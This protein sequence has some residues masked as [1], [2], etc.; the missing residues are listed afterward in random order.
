MNVLITGGAGFIGS[1]LA[2]RLLERGDRVQVIDDLSTGSKQNI[3]HLQ[4]L[5]SFHFSADT[6]TNY[7][8]MA[9]LVDEADVVYHLA[10]AVGV[11]LI[12]ESPTRTMETNI[13]GTEIVLE[14]AARARKRVL[15]TST[16]EVYGKRNHVPFREDDDLVLGPPDKGRWSYACSKAIDEFLA[17]AYWKE[18]GL[19]T[20]VARLFNVVGP[21]QTGR[22]GMVLPNLVKQALSGSD[23][24]VYGDGRQSRCFTYVDDAVGALIALADSP[25]ANGEVYNVGS[26]EEISILDLAERIRK[27]TASES[28]I[29]LVPYEKAYKEGFEDMMRRVPDL[30]KISRAIGYRPSMDLGQILLSTVHYHVEQSGLAQKNGH[31]KT[32]G[33]AAGAH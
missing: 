26:T 16:S 15:I 23:M 10:A 27:M 17:V 12:V 20:V 25:D 21:R 19:P 7:K 8:L 6:V 14:L 31:R 22:Y 18:K 28:R 2:E 9:E 11:R 4:A 24:T 29:I 32:A 33:A 1:H 30:T 3:Q 13:R 5:P